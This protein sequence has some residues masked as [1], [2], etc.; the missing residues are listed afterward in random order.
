MYKK[1]LG[2]KNPADI[3]TKHAAGDLRDKHLETVGVVPMSGRAETAPELMNIQD[4]GYKV[5]SQIEWFVTETEDAEKEIN[6]VKAQ[7]KGEHSEGELRD[8]NGKHVKFS[9]IM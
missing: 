5:E 4:S 9:N 1:I 3:L 2:T 7:S 8:I 6:E